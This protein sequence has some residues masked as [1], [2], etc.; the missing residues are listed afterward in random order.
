MAIQFATRVIDGDGHLIE[1]VAAIRAHLASPYREMT[2]GLGVF[3]PLDH[4]HSGRAVEI[5]PDR[6]RRPIIAAQGWQTFLQD[7][8]ID[9]TVLYPTTALAYGKIVSLD[10]AVAVCRAYNDWLYDTYV[11]VDARF[12]GMA[13]IPLQDPAAAALELR[14]VVTELGFFGAM[15][16]SNG[17]ADSAR[18]AK[19]YWPVYA[20]A[21]R[22]G[23]CLAVHGGCHDRFGMDHMNMYVPMHA[24]GHPWGLDVQLRQ[25]RLQRDLR[26]L[27]EGSRR[28]S[29]RRGRVDAD[30]ARTPARLARD[31]LPIHARPA[32]SGSAKGEDPARATSRSSSRRSGI[33]RASRP[34]S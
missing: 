25:H 18:C 23:C 33:H 11:K 24:L 12:K 26:P 27:P 19:A 15:L 3:P 8:G 2:Y 10:F 9:W 30:V 1:D 16:P 4:L 20:E 32:S 34:R 29:R 22:L 13:I 17:L 7:A 31:A 5:P 6:D 14:R 28:I 21:N